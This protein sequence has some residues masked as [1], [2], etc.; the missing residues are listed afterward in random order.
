MAVE[1]DLEKEA[2][3]DYDWLTKEDY[4]FKILALLAVLADNHLAYRGTLADMC[5]FLGVARGNSRTNGKIKE[6]IEQLET[7]K[8]LHKII[9][10]RTYT[11]T[12]SKK[13]EKQRRIIKI[14]NQWVLVAKNYS[15]MLN[16]SE[17]V[18]WEKLLK[19]WLF[20]LDRGND[21]TPITS[22]AI[23]AALKM[24]E[25]TVKNARAALLKD[26]QAIVAEKK[27]IE[28]PFNNSPW[29]CAGTVITATAW[30]SSE[31]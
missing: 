11:L 24:K 15:Q 9:D 19:V 1:I 14:K 7:D 23:A 10:G 21:T 25:G 6:A 31:P 18:S 20:L 26:I 22:T 5:D 13:A 29:K 17:S 27:Y 3:F 2:E 28:G 30:I 4:Q 16:K 12:L 8:L